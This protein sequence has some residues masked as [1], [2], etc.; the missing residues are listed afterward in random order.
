M[1][2]VSSQR[3]VPRLGHWLLFVLL[4]GTTFGCDRM[5]KRFA[6]L[7][8]AGTSRHSF[9]ADTV[10]LE[11]AENP[12]AF[13]SVGAE[14]PPSVRTSLFT[15]A[16]VVVLVG[17]MFIAVRYQWT[18]VPLAGLAL[19]FAGGASNV[20]DR[21]IRGSVIDFLN[22]GFGPILRSGIF[23][24]ADVAIMAGVAILI[25]TR[26]RLTDPRRI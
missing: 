19:I 22:I 11:Y 25:A 15:V 1:M 8:L 16:T 5:T 4:V 24:V 18:G 17:G 7:E 21:L 26:S 9:F 12:G 3:G 23:N 20:L 6:E 2:L 10:R 13:L 14:L